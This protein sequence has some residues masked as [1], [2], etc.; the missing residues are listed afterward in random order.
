MKYLLLE[1][2]KDGEMLFQM[3]GEKRCENNCIFRVRNEEDKLKLIGNHLRE[4]DKIF[5]ELFRL[6]LKQFDFL[7]ELL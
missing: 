6:C 5:A 4:N 1:E 3:Y 7:V 2:V